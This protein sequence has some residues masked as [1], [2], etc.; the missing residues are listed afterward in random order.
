VSETK[1]GAFGHIATRTKP[2]QRTRAT[3]M[4]GEPPHGR[5]DHGL[6][7]VSTIWGDAQHEIPLAFTDEDG[8]VAV[9][10]GE[11]D[12][13]LA[14]LEAA[15]PEGWRI[16]G[17]WRDIR[18]GWEARANSDHGEERRSGPTLAAALRA[19]AAKLRER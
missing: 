6:M 2:W 9:I 7:P 12:A 3:F 11:L 19:L 16:D 5:L 15:L 4:E 8:C 17:L 13:A 14:E 18:G 10:L 1:I